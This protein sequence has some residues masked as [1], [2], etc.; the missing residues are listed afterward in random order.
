MIPGVVTFNFP[1]I[2][3]NNIDIKI[4]FLEKQLHYFLNSE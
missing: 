2:I 1:K 3:G 4:T